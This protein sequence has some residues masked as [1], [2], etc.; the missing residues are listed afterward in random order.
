VIFLAEINRLM[1]PLLILFFL[2][3]FML[4]HSCQSGDKEAGTPPPDLKKELP[5]TWEAVSVKVQVNSAMN[6]PD[7]SA[8]FEIKEEEWLD[9]MGV[10]PVRTYYQTDNKYRQ[11]FRALNDTLLSIS[12][13]VWNTFGDT[14]MMIE[15]TTTYQY[16]ISLKNGLAEFRALVDW[17]GDGEEDDDYMGVH[18]K[19]SMDVQ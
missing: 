19:V 12:R 13:G 5:G 15:P 1:R 16:T 10:Q 4:L 8:T 3:L 2:S 18:R 9:R 11:E 7:S 6:K 17:D 14:L